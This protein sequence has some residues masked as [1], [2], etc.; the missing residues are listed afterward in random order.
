MLEKHL[1]SLGDLE[2]SI[3]TRGNASIVLSCDFNAWNTEWG[4]RTN[5]P[6]GISLSNFA[7]SLELI[8][9]NT[10]SAPTFA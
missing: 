10:G 3:R 4:S 7:F 6:K 2:A 1:H 8:L 5:N 9:A